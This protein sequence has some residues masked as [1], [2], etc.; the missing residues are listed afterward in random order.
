[1]LTIDLARIARIALL[2]TYIGRSFTTCTRGGAVVD[3]VA[4]AH[5]CGRFARAS[6]PASPRRHEISPRKLAGPK[7]G[8]SE[9]A[10]KDSNLQP[11]D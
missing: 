10:K 6:S 7:S 5:Q 1:M 2:F 9:W 3:P 11:T 4:L 8:S